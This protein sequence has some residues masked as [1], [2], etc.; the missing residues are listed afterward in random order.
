MPN[1]HRPTIHPP[2]WVNQFLQWYCRPDLLEEIQ[3]DAYELYYRTVT[4][5]KPKA[6]FYFLLNVLRFFR[7]RNIK[8]SKSPDTSNYTIM[9][10]SYL[11]T[12][13]RSAFRHRATSIINILGLS[14]GVGVAI[15][16]FLF[17]DFMWNMDSFHVKRDRIYQV[18]SQVTNN[19]TLENWGDSPL[20]LGPSLKS[21][22]SVIESTARVEM[23][24]A[25][26]R[27][28]EAIFNEPV[29]FVDPEF[30]S[31]FSFPIIAGSSNPMVAK[32]SVVLTKAIAEKYFRTES[33]IGQ[34]VSIKFSN[35]TKEEFTV[36]AVIERPENSGMY[37][38]V[39]LS[40]E[41]FAD[42]KFKD[43]YDWSYLTDATF[44]LL[45][46]GHTPFEIVP[47]MNKYKV[48]QNRSSPEW[49]VEK[50]DFIPLTTLSQKSNEI[51]SAISFGAHPAGVWSL[52]VIA[53]LLL[54]LACF[55]YMNVSV[56]TVATRLK[57]IGIR[58]VI[59]S[60]RKEI[61]HQ[62]L[63]ENFVLCIFSLSLGILLSY[64]LL[65]P[66]FNS[67]YPFTISFASSSI[68]T[69]L[70][71]FV[72]LLLF[73][74][75]ISGAYPSLYISSFQPISILRGREKF[76]QRGLFSR[77]LL[78]VQ[79]TLAFTTIVASFIFIDNSLYLKNK[80]W[81]YDHSQNMAVPLA[82]KEQFLHLRDQLSQ[83]QI[84]LLAGSANHIGYNNPRVS[85]KHLEQQ[86]PT[87]AYKIG[88][89][90]LEV[91][92]IRLKE[93]RLFDK[94][95][96][97]D[98][99]ES[100]IV[101]ESF[102]K[103]MNWA[104][105]LKESFVY[106]SVR[107]Y[108]IGVV[109]DFHYNGFYEPLGP[110]MFTISNE[111]DFRFLALNI[112]EGSLQEAEVAVKQLWKE[113]A[114]DDPYEGFAQDT[115][116]EDFHNDNNS[117]ITL[118]TFISTSAIILACL[119]LFGLVSFNI[120][121]RL[122]EFSVRKVFGAS[123]LHIFRLMNKDYTWIILIAFF[124]GAPAGFFLINL[125]IQNVYPDPQPARF[126]P[127]MI[128]ISIIAVTVGITIASQL[129]RVAKENPSVTL[130]ID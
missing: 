122:K 78:T 106:D 5:S 25:A 26:V 55:N 113:I 128:A 118:L 52:G 124:T 119:G 84:G 61:I 65:L 48:L 129:K 88:F 45:K 39:L 121:R 27:F 95:I 46:P 127:F 7:L 36:S 105:P 108:V 91:M 17:M 83:Q 34:Q 90:Y 67:L 2:K 44:I 102:V 56:A 94:K 23:G 109:K 31:M 114:P 130:K 60:N 75:L 64:L 98:L 49:V 16:V 74:G 89:D 43:E 6:D 103:R 62:F 101:N 3:G 104:T 116:F 81:G 30:L 93:G 97:S 14:L 24:G 71:F 77:I 63:T 100:V 85:F 57:E 73:I 96:Q 40:M 70:L 13:I 115:V 110:V 19:N 12:G 72:C 86:F 111:D 79:F 11:L 32:E 29:W 33:P 107:R 28:K 120:T 126:L 22:H 92:N 37:P 69:L 82:N 18:T 4:E 42:L 53:L 38:S 54:L 20:M 112:N 10:K 59:G 123:L 47:N 50:F 99:E 76:G 117:N 66:G 58:K 51:V 1:N 21:D 87:V 80:D 125:A 68:N 41:K 35:G 8:K 9:F 15:T